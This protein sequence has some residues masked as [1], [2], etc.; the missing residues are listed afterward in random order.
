MWRCYWDAF[1]E[2]LQLSGADFCSQYSV[3][4]P[5]REPPEFNLHPHILFF[6]RSFIILSSH[7]C[8]CLQSDLLP[9][10]IPIKI[11]YAYHVSTMSATCPARLIYPD[12]IAQIIFLK[13]ANHVPPHNAVFCNLLLL[14][15][16]HNQIFFSV[17]CS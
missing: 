1:L 11:S 6:L 2:R 15:V 16:S 14:P 17:P 3:I 4:W 13:S 9:R 8:L 10:N 12:F 7:I 5:H